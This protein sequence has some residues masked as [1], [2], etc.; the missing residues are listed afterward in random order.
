M[1][2]AVVE[3]QIRRLPQPTLSNHTITAMDMV[4]MVS[5]IAFNMVTFPQITAVRQF[6]LVIQHWRALVDTAT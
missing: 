1:A 5:L 4:I 3:I 6:V 2:A